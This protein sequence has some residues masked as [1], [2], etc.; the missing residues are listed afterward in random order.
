VMTF[1]ILSVLKLVFGSLR[2]DPEAEAEGLD[3]AEH[4]EAAYTAL[5]GGGSMAPIGASGHG[6]HASAATLAHSRAD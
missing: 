6:M 1:V 3:L 4:S 2:V 5:S